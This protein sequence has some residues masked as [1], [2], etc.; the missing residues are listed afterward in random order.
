MKEILKQLIIDFHQL[1]LPD[2]IPRELDFPKLPTQVR[3][4]YALIG[5]RRSGKT[6]AMYQQM[7]ALMQQGI[8]KEKLVYI[9]FEDDRLSAMTANDLKYVVEAYD[10]LYPQFIHDPEVCFF[11]DEI[12]E[13]SGWEKFIRRL[14]D[15]EKMTL[16]LSG[17]SAKM[18]SQEIATSL[19][20]RVISREIFPFS[21][22][23][24][25]RFKNSA[26]EQPSSKQ[27]AV[28]KHHLNTY[29]RLGGFPETVYL[30]EGLHRELLQSY[31]ESVVYR[32]IVERYKLTNVNA[33]KHLLTHCLKNSATSLSINKI[34]NAFKSRGNA[35]SKNSLYDFMSY[36]EDAYCIFNVPAYVFADRKASLKPKKIYVVDPG[37]VTAYT[38]KEAFEASIRLETV[39]FV[40]LR[41]QTQ[42]I[43]YYST[44]KG[45]E[46]DFLTLTT[47]GKMQM[48]Q[49]TMS[50]SNAETAAREF[51][52]LEEAMQELNVKT[53]TLVVLEGDAKVVKT[54]Y[55][56]IKI[57]PLMDFLLSNTHK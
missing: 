35:I 52:A 47:A 13:I 57:V 18:L 41:R 21:F 36:F 50:L 39:V 15:T 53:A 12:Q 4:A 26:F 8:R 5:M 17:S 22:Y 45:K 2:V 48:Y 54:S 14:L 19:R 43:F 56:K 32:D 20:G 34:Y 25:L 16:Y 37:L 23:E 10:E 1:Q 44:H 49:V 6:W 3:K 24:Y 29:L 46:I 55:G 38:L 51:A 11:L 27:K 33:V 7:Q 30:P 42:N 31:I 40:H 9:N 28:M